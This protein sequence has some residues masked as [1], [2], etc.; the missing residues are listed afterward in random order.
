MRPRASHR[1]RRPAGH[2]SLGRGAPRFQSNVCRL[3]GNRRPLE[4][5]DRITQ[6]SVE[7]GGRSPEMSS[8]RITPAAAASVAAAVPVAASGRGAPVVVAAPA[9]AAGL[10]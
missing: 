4:V 8:L 1:K 10:T 5:S 2:P 6:W 7:R 3:Y 9:V